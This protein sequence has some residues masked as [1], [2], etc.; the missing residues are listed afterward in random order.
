MLFNPDYGVTGLFAM[1]FYLIF[2][3]LGPFIE[4][5]GYIIFVFCLI[6]GMVNY[7]FAILF[8]LLAVVIGTLLSLLAILLEEYSPHRYSRLRDI[9]VI[10]LCC[11]LE[12][13]LYR[14]WLA[15]VRF[16]AFFDFFKGKEEWGVMEKKGF[17]EAG[18]G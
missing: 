3:M 16:I 4:I 12:N 15:V 2:E 10:A 9:L 14:Q 18:S 6:F 13:I 1:P 7:P 17:A 5:T 8:F 11:L